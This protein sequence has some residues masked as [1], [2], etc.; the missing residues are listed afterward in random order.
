M[1]PGRAEV[2]ASF[3][4]IDAS[5]FRLV[6]GSTFATYRDRITGLE[7][8]VDG[9]VRAVEAFASPVW[10]MQGALSYNGYFVISGVCPAYADHIGDGVDYPSCLHRGTGGSSTTTWTQ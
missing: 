3:P 7:L 4:R 6:A 2:A 10:G 9:Y 5:G 8:G 1:V